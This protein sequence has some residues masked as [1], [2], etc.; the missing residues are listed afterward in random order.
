[1]KEAWVGACQLERVSTGFMME[2]MDRVPRPVPAATPTRMTVWGRAWFEST[3][4]RLGIAKEAMAPVSPLERAATDITMTGWAPVFLSVHVLVAITM[5]ETECALLLEFAQADI[6]MVGMVSVWR[7]GCVALDTTTAARA[8]VCSWEV[9]QVDIKMVA[10]VSVCLRGHVVL[11][12]GAM[13][14]GGV[15]R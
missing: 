12:F 8:T 11:D 15:N 10:M 1:M 9:V 2:G 4:V 5:V 14:R 13:A 3:R 7:L 6:A